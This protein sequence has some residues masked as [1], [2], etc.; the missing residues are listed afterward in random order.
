MIGSLLYHT[1]VANC[2]LLVTLVSLAS[3]HT[4]ASTE[5]RDAIVW[6]LNY[7]TTYPDV[8]V[9]YVVS[10]MC[11]NAHRDALYFMFPN[12]EAE[13]RGEGHFFGDKPKQGKSPANININD[14]IH[15]V[16][17]ISNNVLRSVARA[18]IEAGYINTRD[19]L[20]IH[21]C[22]GEMVHP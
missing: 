1:L 20:S 16:Y 17:K 10:D 21:V 5:T 13:R 7:A 14:P 9:M 2:T 22:S 11:L 12:P 8:E 18:K 19:L 15:V 3:T 6:L 4:Q